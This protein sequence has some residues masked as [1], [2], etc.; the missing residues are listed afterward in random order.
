[1]NQMNEKI[2]R[3]MFIRKKKKNKYNAG[4]AMNIS[5]KKKILFVPRPILEG[6]TFSLIL[7]K[8]KKYVGSIKKKIE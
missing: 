5:S 8:K 3:Q 4:I 7:G 2:D 6:T 1:M